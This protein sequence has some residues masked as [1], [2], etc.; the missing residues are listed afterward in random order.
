MNPAKNV[1][2][3]LGGPKEVADILGIHV[4]AV[5]K[6]TYGKDRKGT[7]GLVPM[8]HAAVLMCHARN[9]DIDLSPSDF[10]E[11]GPEATAA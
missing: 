6:W 7:G 4:S 11:S 10:F 8:E 9:K 2:E 1:I 3:K 5:Y